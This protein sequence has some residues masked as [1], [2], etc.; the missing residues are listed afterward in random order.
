MTPTGRL[1][2]EAL[3][4]AL[5]AE[6][7]A[8]WA[9][10]LTSAFLADELASQLAEAAAAHRARRDGAEQML[11]DAGALPVPAEPGYLTPEPIT[12]NASALRLAITVETDTAA[13]WRSVIERSPAEPGLRQAAL[14]ALIAAAV[15]AAHWRTTAH[16]AP[17]TVPFPGAP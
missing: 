12:D 5:A 17:A 13:A 9:Y 16:S 11:V 4:S 15:Q 2:V 1:P 10:G 14:D 6:H 3:Q 8:V 7:A